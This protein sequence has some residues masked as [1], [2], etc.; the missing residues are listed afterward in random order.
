M[1]STLSAQ[2]LEVWRGERC[3]FESLDFELRA[4]QTAVLVGPNGAGKTTLLRVL[5]GLAAPTH[6]R[7]LFDGTEVRSLLPEQRTAIAYRGHLDGLKK[8]LSV[9][10]NLDYQRQLNRSETPLEPLLAELDLESKRDTR[11]RHLSAGQRRRA[12]LAAL[13][14]TGATLWILDEPTTNLDAEGRALVTRWVRAHV[15]AGG[16]AIVATHQAGELAQPGAL[17]IEL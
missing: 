4:G 6:G 12:S 11:A 16:L 5:A 10:E 17:M 15:D 2:A 13:K 7:V 1:G 8:D 9:Y 14:L 3:L